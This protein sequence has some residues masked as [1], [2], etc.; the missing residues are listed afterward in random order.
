MIIPLQNHTPGEARRAYLRIQWVKFF[1][2]AERIYSDLGKEFKGTFHAE[3]SWTPAT[4][5]WA[6]WRCPP[7]EASPREQGRPSRRRSARRFS[8]TP[9]GIRM[10]RTRRHHEHDVQPIGEEIWIQP[11][12]TRSRI[13]S[14]ACGRTIEWQSGSPR[15]FLEVQVWRQA[16]PEVDDD[17]VGRSKA[18]HEADCDQAIRNVMQAGPRVSRNFEVGQATDRG[19]KKDDP[20]YWRGPARVILVSLPTTL[21]FSYRNHVMK[22]CQS[23]FDMPA[24]KN[25]SPYQVGSTTSRR[26]GR[27]WRARRYRASRTRTTRRSRM[28]S[29]RRRTRSSRDS[30]SMR[31]PRADGR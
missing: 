1:G 16:G 19:V 21:W 22:P 18:H 6:P 15:Y 3:P 12:S 13:H 27:C 11:S 30:D 20:K 26:P 31:R 23:R 17:E 4:L 10:A 24:T 8:T 25:S 7:R 9:A 14:K 29:G 2:P 5:T 28:S